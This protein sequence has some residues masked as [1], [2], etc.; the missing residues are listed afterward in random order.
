V[1]VPNITLE[2]DARRIAGDALATVLGRLDIGPDDDPERIR[3][4]VMRLRTDSSAWI[5][6]RDSLAAA[7]M[8]LYRALADPAECADTMDA[9]GR[10][11]IGNIELK[12]HIAV[13]IARALDEVRA[14]GG[15]S[16]LCREGAL[17]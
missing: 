9:Y 5:E 14:A 2:Q 1:K 6:P 4:K 12:E 7:A 8:D 11:S 15:A 3:A 10:A 17:V 13:T 16:D